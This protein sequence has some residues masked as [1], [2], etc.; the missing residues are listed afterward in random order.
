MKKLPILLTAGVLLVTGALA[1]RVVELEGRLKAAERRAVSAATRQPGSGGPVVRSPIAASPRAKAPEPRMAEDLANARAEVADLRQQIQAS[2]QQR[3]SPGGAVDGISGALGIR[4]VDTALV[5]SGNVA[6]EHWTG[7]EKR[8]WGHE[9]AAGAPD[10]GQPGD[11]PSAWASKAPD[12]G[13]EWL[14][15]D[16]DR[17]VDLQQINVVESHNPGAIS[18]VVAMLSNG[19]EATIWEG[20]MEPSASDE[21]VSSAF[22]VGESIRARSVKVY[23]DT[24]RVPGWNEIDA[25][26]VVGRDGSKQWATSSRASSSYADP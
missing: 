22:P 10:T 20:S 18:K 13:E 24:A 23:M 8:R 1:L 26:E 21:L 5:P 11:I 4:S 15:L 12:G 3:L 17:F 6:V 19:R 7:G 2:Q 16:Y 14:Q 25:V 9:Q